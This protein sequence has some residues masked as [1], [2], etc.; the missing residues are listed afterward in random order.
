MREHSYVPAFEAAQIEMGVGNLDRALALLEEGVA[1]RDSYA[2]FLKAW[3][4]FKPLR[5]EPAFR[6]LLARIGLES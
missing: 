1:N 4:S 3:L 2:V 5:G 6:R